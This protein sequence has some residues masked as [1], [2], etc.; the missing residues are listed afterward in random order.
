[1]TADGG[2]R[3]LG[4]PRFDVVLRGYDRRQ[5]DEHV[6]RLQRVLGR[7]RAD[8]DA[9][10]SQPF[11]AVGL[12]GVPQDRPRPTPRPRP[13]AVPAP[14]GSP[15]MIGSFTDR[16]QSIL[17]AA[18]E[19]AEEIRGAARVAAQREVEAARAAA[20]HDNESARAELADILR[21]RDEVVA[22]L[23]RMRGQ[24]EGLLSAPTAQFVAQPPRV[25]RPAPRVAP[26]P[27][28]P[29]A[30]AQPLPGAHA[31]SGKPVAGTPGPGAHE[32]EQDR[33]T[34]MRVRPPEPARADAD[35]GGDLFRATDEPGRPAEEHT[36][37]VPLPGARDKAAREN[38]RERAAQEKSAGEKPARE[39]SARE[40]SARDG[41]PE[42][43][44]D[45]A[46]R[47]TVVPV[48]KRA[49]D[50][51]SAENAAPSGEPS[52]ADKTGLMPVRRPA[53]DKER[54]DT[55]AEQTVA[56]RAVRPTPPPPPS[57]GSSK[58][59]RSDGSEA[60]QKDGGPAERGGP[61]KGAGNHGHNGRGA[62]QTHPDRSTS[63]SRSG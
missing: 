26:A 3:P 17:Q 12:Q 55:A 34:A 41:A 8:L 39:Q 32:A 52:D 56:V 47:T 50:T 25:Q 28:E 57:G 23:T 45:T 13:G 62:E 38:A 30:A 33:T 59:S 46:E 2:D 31:G 4:A 54:P 21:Q 44:P 22:E 18:E 9:A 24:L 29:G 1:M 27:A 10:R 37:A 14:A 15:D 60:A 48:L 42:P 7:M 58:N 51:G 19:E 6:A 61:A 43:R 40:Q 5:V 49:G 53:E 36:T 11:P 35:R 20:R 63:G 16:M